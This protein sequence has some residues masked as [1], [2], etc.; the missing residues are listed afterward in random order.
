M[1]YTLSLVGAFVIAC[2]GWSLIGSGTALLGSLVLA[3]CFCFAY[4]ASV[5]FAFGSFRNFIEKME[6]TWQFMTL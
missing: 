6:E 4:A 3:L 1:K 2:V 5:Y